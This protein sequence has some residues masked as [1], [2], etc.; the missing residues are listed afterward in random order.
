MQPPTFR[1]AIEVYTRQIT[2]EL[3]DISVTVA[4]DNSCV[5]PKCKSGKV[6]FYPK[7]AK[8]SDTDCGLIIFRN[9]SEKLLSDK[10]VTDLLAKGKTSIIKGFKSKSGKSFDA[11]LKFDA[12]FQVVFDFPDKKGK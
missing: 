12:D 3:L 6:I 9:K 1:Q 10:Q 5:C 4:G 8:C 2:K 11:A 7:V